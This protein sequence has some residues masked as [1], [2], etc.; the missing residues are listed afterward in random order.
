MTKTQI[1]D[2]L[3]GM[4]AIVSLKPN[5][6]YAPA[7]DYYEITEERANAWMVDWKSSDPGATRPSYSTLINGGFTFSA[8]RK[9]WLSKTPVCN[10][11]D[12]YGSD[13]EIHGPRE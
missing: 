9:S 10:C 7:V 3:I 8:I 2:A 6:Q 1:R 12:P 13:C 11:A 5:G 4:S